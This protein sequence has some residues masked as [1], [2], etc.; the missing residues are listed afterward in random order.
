[1][2]SLWIAV[3]GLTLLGALTLAVLL[4]RSSRLVRPAPSALSAPRLHGAALDAHLTRLGRELQP[5]GYRHM[6]L[7]RRTARHLIALLRSS[8][9]PE[10]GREPGAQYLRDNSRALEEAL[11]TLQQELRT[12]PALPA[13]HGGGLRLTAFTEAL[14]QAR[15]GELSMPDLPHYLEIWQESAG[16]TEDEL[17]ALPQALRL[18]L[19]RLLTATALDVRA[20]RL[21]RQRGARLAAKLHRTADP[22]QALEQSNLTPE[23]FDGLVHAMEAH[24]DASLLH[25]LD[26]RLEQAGLEA[27][28]LTRQAR[29]REMER[30][31]WAAALSGSLRQLAQVIWPEF[32]ERCDPL[33]RCLSDDPA[34]VYPRMDF[35][36]RRMYVLRLSLIHI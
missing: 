18:T 2:L 22:A 36:S 28:A 6:R 1:M 15:Q 17:Q 29:E 25:E 23:A 26:L 7:S 24:G 34:G 32:L 9:R 12:L 14:L 5:K 31:H 21:E 30:G 27:E 3:I 8:L 20:A 16:M 33:H 35:E 4:H 13:L 19:L 10:H 11:L